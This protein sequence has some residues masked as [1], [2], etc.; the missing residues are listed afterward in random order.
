MLQYIQ[1]LQ[2]K[3]QTLKNCQQFDAIVSNTKTVA[4]S[5]VPFIKK[6]GQVQAKFAR[7]LKL[8]DS[9]SVPWTKEPG[10]IQKKQEI[11][12]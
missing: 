6:V 9:H 2:Q 12:T 7:P 10:F 11:N 3:K 1:N 8:R 4:K 5:M